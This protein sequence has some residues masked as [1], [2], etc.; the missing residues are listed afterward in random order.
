MK[1]AT[2]TFFHCMRKK[3]I[4]EDIE[5]KQTL[6]ELIKPSKDERAKGIIEKLR[7][8][9]EGHN[10]ALKECEAELAKALEE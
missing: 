9:I 1:D 2:V 7:A 8:E 3:S 4:E 6:V 5:Y 10:K